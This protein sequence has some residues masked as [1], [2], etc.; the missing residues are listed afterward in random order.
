MLSLLTSRTESS[1][2][3]NTEQEKSGSRRHTERSLEITRPT[4][5]RH[6]LTLINKSWTEARSRTCPATWRKAEIVAIRKMGKPVAET[7]SYR[8]ISL[9]SSISRLAE[10]MVQDRLQ[11]WLESNQKLNPS[12]AGFR[13]GRSTIDQLTKITQHIFDAL[14]EKK[15]H[16]VVLVL[17]DFARARDRVWR[18]ALLAKLG[19]LGVPGYVCRWISALLSDR[20]ARVR[21]GA[22][23]SDSST[24]V[25]H[26]YVS[27]FQK[28]HR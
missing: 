19:R 21:W 18:A 2:Q 6:L 17:L 1:P 7:S 25:M 20:R 9:L 11:H 8:P 16:R 12:Q 28:N 22:T 4:A 26:M 5:E 23:L 10:R 14:E 24:C 13:R 27:W 15:P 3:Q